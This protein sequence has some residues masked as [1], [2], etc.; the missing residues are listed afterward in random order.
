MVLE[1]ITV[2]G[3]REHNLK[4][5]DLVIPKNSLTVFTGLSGS[6]KSTLAFDTIYAE[7][8]RR[9]VESLSSYARQFL[10]VMDKPDVDSIEGLSPAISI[11]QKGAGHNPRSTVGTVTEIYDYLRL[12]YARV[13]TP[14]CPKC[15]T[16]ISASSVQTMA[17]AAAN[18][19][20][21][22]K[23]HV[24]APIVRGKKGTYE[25]LFSEYYNKGFVAFRVDGKEFVMDESQRTPKLA[26]YEKHEIWVQA[27]R[28]DCTRE[29]EPRLAEALESACAAAGGLAVVAGEDG[30]EEL[31]NQQSSCPDCGTSFEE[32]QPRL[33]SFNSPFGACTTCHGLGVKSEF[34]EGL[35]IPD[36]NKAIEDGA[37][38]PWGGMF[39]SFRIQSLEALGHEYG[40]SVKDPISSLNKEQLKAVLYG[41]DRKIKYRHVSRDK[42]S[43]FAHEGGFEGVIPNLTRL[44]SQTES[45]YRR[46]EISKYMITSTCPACQGRRLKPEALAVK[47]DK[48][49][50]AELCDLDVETTR[51]RLRKL[52]LSDTHKEISRLIMK[53]LE[54]RL[55]FLC[56]VGLGYV[57][58]GRSAATL[59]GGE[60]QRIR[61]ATQIGSGLTGVLYVLDE[62]SIGLHQKDNDK[63]LAT[64]KKLRDLGNTLIVVEHDRDTMLAADNIVDLGPGA[65]EKGGRIVA[66][67]APKDFIKSKDSLTAAY[68]RGDEQIA[69]PEKRRTPYEYLTIRGCTGNNLKNIDARFPLHALTAVTGVSGS[70]KSTLVVDT[71]QAALF[72]RKYGSKDK[73]LPF[74]EIEGD[75]GVDHVVC[76]DQSPIGRTPRSNPATYIGAF[77]P[78]RELFASTPESRARGFKPGRFSFNVE[79]GRCGNCS[80]DGVIKI[81]MHFLPDVY[82]E[83]EECKGKRYEPQ[84]LS[85]RY[86][87]KNIADVLAMSVAE[88]LEF[89]K[90]IPQIRR[91]LQTINDV[92]LGYIK[93]GQPSNTLSGGEAQ[94][95]KLASELCKRDTGRTVYVLDEPTTG[96]H[97]DDV[98]KLLDVLQKLVQ[99]RN[100]VIVIEHNLD[101]IKATD[102]IVD[103][104]PAGGNA[105]GQVVATGTPEQ[106]A[107][108]NKSE[109]GR[110]LKPVM[111]KDTKK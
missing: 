9:Y 16:V 52:K 20:D 17:Q 25:A 99:R 86:R 93:L 65:G 96:L 4:N 60:A 3:A 107:Q 82:V 89:F 110:Y 57:S 92:G 68:L 14:H 12:L 2:R 73:P 11:D 22:K 66:T 81:E 24:Y 88:S 90:N 91:K 10:G 21:G 63:L 105:G 61:L 8:Q 23:I 44:L 55:S 72:E 40:F 75:A 31:F 28:F 46:E 102:W 62:P 74:K 94:R 103:L 27:D 18:T 109:T 34:D 98:K 37:V 36:K 100:T 54:A 58:L 43:L 51:E 59:S 85:I 79:G 49:S 64:L 7:G 39:K 32:L 97:F 30:G 50:I 29:N 104:G 101:L 33:F 47:I 5:I 48:L 108:N 69:T 106:V 19:F 38:A 111:E 77:S 26:R 41:S 70:G 71:L 45:N 83:C 84:T 95:I 53:E 56:D 76:V 67:G 42:T 13:G 15:N 35:I 78:I 87:G 6:G 1:N 80:G